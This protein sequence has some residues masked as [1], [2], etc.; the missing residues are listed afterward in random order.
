MKDK[1]KEM[2]TLKKLLDFYKENWDFEEIKHA[3]FKLAKLS[4]YYYIELLIWLADASFL[5]DLHLLICDKGVDFFENYAKTEKLS[6]RLFTAINIILQWYKDIYLPILYKKHA[7]NASEHERIILELLRDNKVLELKGFM[8]TNQKELFGNKSC[9]DMVTVYVLYVLS[10]ERSFDNSICEAALLLYTTRLRYVRI[11]K[12]IMKNL[13]CEKF[14]ALNAANSDH[15]RNVIPLIFRIHIAGGEYNKALMPKIHSILDS[16]FEYTCPPP[17]ITIINK[18]PRVAVCIS[19]MTRGLNIPIKSLC[20]NIVLPLNADVFLSTWDVME[21]WPGLGGSHSA[22]RLFGDT[23]ETK[24]FIK[25]FYDDMIFEK[26]FPNMYAFLSTKVFASFD[27]SFYTE[28]L[29]ITSLKVESEE[30]FLNSLPFDAN[31]LLERDSHNQAKMFYKIYSALQLALK[32]EEEHNFKYDYII[33]VRPDAIYNKL[34]MIESLEDIGHNEIVTTYSNNVGANDAFWIGR[35]EAMIKMC[36]IWEQILVTENFFIFKNR[37]YRSHHLTAAWLIKQ[38]LLTRNTSVISSISSAT[39]DIALDTEKLKSALEKDFATTAV[40]YKNNE[41]VK[42]FFRFIAKDD[43][44][45]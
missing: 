18:K 38:N 15:F 23:I 40:A 24:N 39:Q 25:L 33:R 13:D 19:G 29:N 37:K 21:S 1:I 11:V 43:S 30:F 14:F 35:H 3:Y 17:P 4:D 5:Y 44:V 2:Q 31:N 27:I 36:S 12:L 8:L 32:Y 34:L 22:R 41:D 7:E 9:R 6:K 42:R 26:F 16:C 10:E 28:H 45:C 20:A